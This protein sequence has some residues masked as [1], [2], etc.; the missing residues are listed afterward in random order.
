[1]SHLKSDVFHTFW[2][3]YEIYKR[4]KGI[5]LRY[6]HVLY[7]FILFIFPT[8]MSSNFNTFNVLFSIRMGHLFFFNTFWVLYEIYKRY[9]G[10][11]IKNL[12]VSC[13]YFIYISYRYSYSALECASVLHLNSA[14]NRNENEVNIVNS[15]SKELHSDA[16]GE[17]GWQFSCRLPIIKRKPLGA[18]CVGAF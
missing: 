1:M 4:Y 5:R 8:N 12:H 10:I 2:V 9:K 17:Y 3:L 16:Y 14:R 6:L 15:N 13:F 7:S 11:R 18:V